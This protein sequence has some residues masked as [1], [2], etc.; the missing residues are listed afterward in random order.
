MVKPEEVMSPKSRLR[1]P[2][3][4]LV[5]GGE[6]SFS[7]ARF[8]WDGVPAVG[9][10][11]NGEADDGS[12]ARDA[13]NP[14]SRGLPTW[15]ILPKPVA[16]LVVQNKDA[17]IASLSNDG[18]GVVDDSVPAE[19]LEATIEKVAERVLERLLKQQQGA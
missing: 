10:R 7:V 4:V 2:I 18:R 1:G 14:Q 3:E 6:G 16:D 13:G 15:F 19:D 9:I 11:W 5:P 8:K 17:I 12:G